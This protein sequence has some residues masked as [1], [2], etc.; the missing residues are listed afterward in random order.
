[1]DV[2]WVFAVV[3]GLL[4]VLAGGAVAAVLGVP[5]LVARLTAL[6][7]WWRTRRADRCVT[8]VTRPAR[9]AAPRRR[10]A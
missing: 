6:A 3:A 7:A 5:A 4:L 9:H 1:M 8:T 10:H 2:V